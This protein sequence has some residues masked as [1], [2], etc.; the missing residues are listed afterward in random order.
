MNAVVNGIGWA[1]AWRE[2]VAACQ[3]SDDALLALADQSEVP[4]GLLLYNATFPPLGAWVDRPTRTD[5][6]FEEPSTGTRSYI[7]W[8]NAN[9][10]VEAMDALTFAATH[11]LRT[12]AS[13][14]LPVAITVAQAHDCYVRAYAQFPEPLRGAFF[15]WYELE[16]RAEVMRDLA[17][18]CR[19]IVRERE[20]QRRTQLCSAAP[21]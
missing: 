18:L 17:T 20:T 8:A 12:G 7:G 6:G 15:R 2:V 14:S 9:L 3:F 10:A 16:S 4:G 1:T 5:E 13:G 19:R 11:A 21:T